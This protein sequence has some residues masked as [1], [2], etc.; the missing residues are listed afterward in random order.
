MS[1][2][3]SPSLVS[4]TAE[5]GAFEQEAPT[6]WCLRRRRPEHLDLGLCSAANSLAP[7]C[8]QS[9]RQ[10]GWRLTRAH[11]KA[12]PQPLGQA[13]PP[14]R[15]GED[16]PFVVTSASAGALPAARAAHFGF[17]SSGAA[18]RPG[19]A[20]RPRPPLRSWPR[21]LAMKSSRLSLCSSPAAPMTT[22]GSSKRSRPPCSPHPRQHSLAVFLKH[23]F[24]TVPAFPTCARLLPPCFEP[25]LCFFKHCTESREIICH[26]NLPSA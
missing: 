1:R 12:S 25:G 24:K 26:H 18:A 8:N 11:R 22:S 10:G 19:E 16:P 5:A 2:S 4:V 7:S 15:E 20:P 21:A 14:P 17:A 6:M 3:L 13:L 23:H 9:R